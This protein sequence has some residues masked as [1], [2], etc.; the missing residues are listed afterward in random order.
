MNRIIVFLVIIITN[1]L[2]SQNNS[3]RASYK[4]TINK[5]NFEKNDTIVSDNNKE[6]INYFKTILK[7]S[8]EKKYELYYMDS[9]SLFVEKAE[10]DNATINNNAYGKSTNDKLFVNIILNQYVNQTEFLGKNF[11]IIDS[12]TKYN[13]DISTNESKIIA[14]KKVYKATCIINTVQKEKTIT[15]W[16]SAELKNSFGPELFC[17]LPGLVLELNTGDV[18]YTC[19]DINSSIDNLSIIKKPT[20]GKKVSQKEFDEITYQ[21]QMELKIMGY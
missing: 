3:G 7:N 8:I 14:N 15:A 4:V 11:L 12:L 16:Y 13:W 20:S 6:L 17:G 2:F 5:K 10:L 9:T 19:Y 18:T 1:S 21:K